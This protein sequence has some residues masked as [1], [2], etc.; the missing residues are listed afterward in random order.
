MKTKQYGIIYLAVA[1]LGLL[2]FTPTVHADSVSIALTQASQSSTPGST[3]TFDA[4][5]VNLSSTDTIFLNGD[6][7]ATSSLLLT[8]DD[9]PFL[10]NF[11][12]SLGP[13]ASS[14]P[15]AFFS[16]LIDPSTPAGIYDFNQFS[17]LGGLDGSA[18]DTLGTAGF[19]V[20]VTPA[21]A[22]P[23]PGEISLLFVTSLILVGGFWCR[24]QPKSGLISRKTTIA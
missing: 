4:T 15:F 22:V 5:L 24:I 2:C 11:P 6:S 14:G 21:V 1:V 16:V 3:V 17:L 10:T 7:S 19:S 18:F 8:V 13:G 12:L 9:T 23:E 20:T